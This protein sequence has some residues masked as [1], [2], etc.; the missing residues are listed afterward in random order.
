MNQTGKT[1]KILIWLLALT[2]SAGTV[3]NYIVSPASVLL[4]N[5]SEL[6]EPLSKGYLVV[7]SYVSISLYKRVWLELCEI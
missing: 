1:Q 4:Q 3:G 6:M 5:I 7:P 2:M